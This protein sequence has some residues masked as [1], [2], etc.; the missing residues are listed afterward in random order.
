VTEPVRHDVCEGVTIYQGEALSVLPL[1]PAG[2][3]DSVLTDP[4]Y[5]T[6]APRDGYGRREK[7]SGGQ[8]I[9]GDEDLSLFA[10]AL[11]PLRRVL[12]HDGWFVFFCSPKRRDELVPIT[13]RAGLRVIGEVVWDKAAPGLGGGIRYQHETVLLCSWGGPTGRCSLPSVIREWVPKGQH[14]H[15]QQHHP[16]EK[17][18]GLLAYLVQYASDPGAVVLDPF[19]GSGST[20]VACLHA[21]RRFVGIEL[22]PEYFAVARHRLSGTRPALGISGPLFDRAPEEP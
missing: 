22:D 13:C 14:C 4:P 1:L 17:P 9:A 8:H 10:A 5:G 18:L 19:M 15:R 16:H 2:S 7:W 11:P 20:G 12:V 3:V 21:G 6:D